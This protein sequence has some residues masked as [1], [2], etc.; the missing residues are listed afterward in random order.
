MNVHKFIALTEPSSIVSTLS[1]FIVGIMFTS[2]DY[3]RLDIFN[4]LVLLLA[5]LAIHLMANAL[6]NL[7][8]Y[9]ASFQTTNSTAQK[10]RQKTNSLGVHGISF[11]AAVVTAAILGMITVILGIYLLFATTMWLLV[12]GIIGFV[13]SYLYSGGKLPI[14][15]T[16]FGEAACSL[17]MGVGITYTVI[18]VNIPVSQFS[19]N[20]FLSGFLV[21]TITIFPLA[22]IMLANNAC[23]V[24][25]DVKMDRHTIVS[26]IG[27]KRALEAFAAN[28]VITYI[29]VI[30]T[31][32][33]RLLPISMLLVLVTIPIVYKHVKEFF[34]VQ[35]KKRTFILS[36]RNSFAIVTMITIAGICE[37]LFDGLIK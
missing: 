14:S 12:I 35:D 4:S 8:D 34:A 23:D 13:I 1:P 29:M 2:Y 20:L 30:V 19:W 6:D 31:V 27:K 37:L 15:H 7:S 17:T 9:R 32:L 33:L 24:A 11:K 21:A 5:C 36:V 16:P 22:S 10:F 26:V 28:Y 25:E 3:G 18:M